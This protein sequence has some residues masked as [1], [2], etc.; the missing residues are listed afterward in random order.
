MLI[1]VFCITP[2]TEDNTRWEVPAE[3]SWMNDNPLKEI[4]PRELDPNNNPVLFVAFIP[5]LLSCA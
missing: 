4:D 1:F 3:P 2:P 5:K